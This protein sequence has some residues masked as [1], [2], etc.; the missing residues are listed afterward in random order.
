MI[1][2]KHNCINCFV[3]STMVFTSSVL[4]ADTLG[5][6]RLDVGSESISLH[7]MML[8]VGGGGVLILFTWCPGIE[9]IC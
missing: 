4:A 1:K 7:M 9:T 6:K 3:G 5:K 2:I 8:V